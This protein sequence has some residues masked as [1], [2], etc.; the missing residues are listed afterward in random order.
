MISLW[1]ISFSDWKKNWSHLAHIEWTQKGKWSTIQSLTSY[2]EVYHGVTTQQ[3]WRRDNCF[4][5]CQEQNQVQSISVKWNYDSAYL[6]LQPYRWL[7]LCSWSK[8]S[9]GSHI[10]NHIIFCHII[11]FKKGNF[12]YLWAVFYDAFLKFR[13]ELFIS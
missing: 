5:S 8:D 9:C 4:N 10:I 12:Q 11:S 1:H 7:Q 2:C 3:C 6:D 13:D